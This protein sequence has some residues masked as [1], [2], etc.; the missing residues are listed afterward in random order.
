MAVTAWFKKERKPRTSQRSRLEIPKDAWDKC[1][2][3]DHVDIRERFERE[4]NVCPNCGHH[5]RFSAEEYLELLSDAGSWRELNQN[6]RPLDPL[7]FENYPDRAKAAL[8]KTGQ[9]DAIFTG[10][11]KL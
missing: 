3:C 5:R 10:A 9:L 7:K 4:L 11:A 8:T 1:E 6:L 2:S